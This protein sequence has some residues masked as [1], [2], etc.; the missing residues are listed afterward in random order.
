MRRRL[1]H[2][3]TV[4]CEPRQTTWQMLRATHFYGELYSE[5]F[6][7]SKLGHLL[8]GSEPGIKVSTVS[9]Q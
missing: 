2:V 9:I 3:R 1:R 5:R 8:G 6:N 4:R 7:V